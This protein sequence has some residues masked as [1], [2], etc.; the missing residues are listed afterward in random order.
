MVAAAAAAAV[1]HGHGHGRVRPILHEC[2]SDKS[3]WMDL[4]SHRSHHIRRVC[5]HRDCAVFPRR[6]ERNLQGCTSRT[7]VAAVHPVDTRDRYT[8]MHYRQLEVGRSKCLPGT[9]EVRILRSAGK[10]GS[11]LAVEDYR[12]LVGSLAHCTDPRSVV[13]VLR[14]RLA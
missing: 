4:G 13:R 9:A 10:V 14:I 3:R 1:D 5:S 8:H 12:D 6:L 2:C 11:R 7:A